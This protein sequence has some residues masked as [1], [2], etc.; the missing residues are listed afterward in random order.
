MTRAFYM[1][2]ISQAEADSLV[3]AGYGHT[4]R[5][6][7]EKHLAEIKKP[8]TDPF[9]AAQYKLYSIFRCVVH[10]RVDSIRIRGRA[11]E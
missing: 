9:Y 4:E 2:A 5:E 7:A 10:P 3:Q 8:P 1:P 11:G 6:A